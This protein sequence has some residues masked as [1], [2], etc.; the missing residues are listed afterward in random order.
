MKPPKRYGWRTS[1]PIR[2]SDILRNWCEYYGEQ[3]KA[4]EAKIAALEK[5]LE[6]SEAK[7]REAEEWLVRF[8][9]AIMSGFGNLIK[10]AG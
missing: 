6:I 4:A 1:A 8:H 9:D 2:Q 5:R 7:A 10:K 3:A